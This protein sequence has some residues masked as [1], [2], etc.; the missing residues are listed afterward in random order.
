MG[1]NHVGSHIGIGELQKYTQGGG[2]IPLDANF[3]DAARTFKQETTA[4]AGGVAF[5]AVH[6]FAHNKL[7]FIG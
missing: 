6:A 7:Q 1:K 5:D 4:C 3:W 2:G